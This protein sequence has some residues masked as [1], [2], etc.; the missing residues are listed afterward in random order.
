MIKKPL[1]SPGNSMAI[2]LG[3]GSLI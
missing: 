1:M 3:I 2:A